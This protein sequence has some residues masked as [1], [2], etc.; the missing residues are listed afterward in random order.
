[1]KFLLHSLVTPIATLLERT[2]DLSVQQLAA[3]HSVLQVYKVKQSKEPSYIYER[4]FPNGDIVNEELRISRSISNR[5]IRIENNLSLARNT[6][7]YRAS[8]LWNALPSV[9]KEL[10]SVHC[11]KKQTKNWIKSSVL[12]RPA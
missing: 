12:E 8:K 1:M 10:N 5:D 7:F 11:F 9:V 4:L 3:Y 2:G 6:F